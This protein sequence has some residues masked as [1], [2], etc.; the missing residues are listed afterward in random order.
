MNS[1]NSSLR[2]T[3]T[4][5]GITVDDVAAIDFEVRVVSVEGN[6]F[7]LAFR[8]LFVTVVKLLTAVLG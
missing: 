5:G 2:L 1:D 4:L 8:F 6:V 7:I 3:S